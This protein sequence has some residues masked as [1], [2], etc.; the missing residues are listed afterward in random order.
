MSMLERNAM[1]EEMIRI[2]LDVEEI[3]YFVRAGLHAAVDRET[4]FPPCPRHHLPTMSNTACRCTGPSGATA[5]HGYK[6]PRE[7]CADKI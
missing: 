3:C 6:G 7:T 1:V 2:G 5:F 4:K